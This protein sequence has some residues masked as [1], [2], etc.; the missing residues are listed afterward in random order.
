MNYGMW[1][2]LAAVGAMVLFM[3]AVVLPL[4][5]LANRPPECRDGTRRHRWSN[6]SYHHMTGNTRACEVCGYSENRK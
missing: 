2:V 1:E 5:L 4:G 6:W 3:L